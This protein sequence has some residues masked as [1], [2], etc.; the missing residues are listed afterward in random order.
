MRRVAGLFTG[1][2][3]ALV[4][5]GWASGGVAAGSELGTPVR[6]EADG[7]PIDVDVGHAAPWVADWDGDGKADLLVG[8]F[9]D[10]KLRIYRNLGTP[11]APKYGAATWFEAGGKTGAV[12]SG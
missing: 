1:G 2:L 4:V 9:G 11:A 12:P 5:G 7:K 10:G 6:I 8:Q 3:A